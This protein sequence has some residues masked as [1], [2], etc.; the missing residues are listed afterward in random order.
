MT[1]P[2]PWNQVPQ[3]PRPW[4]DPL[5]LIVCELLA[6]SFAAVGPVARAA[7]LPASKPRMVLAIAIVASLAM[8]GTRASWWWVRLAIAVSAGA[9]LVVPQGLLIAAWLPAT[10]LLADW[11]VR[12]RRPF[13]L[14]PPAPEGVLVPVG[15]AVLVAAQLG[16]SEPATWEPLAAMAV[17]WILALLG[18]VMQKVIDRPGIWLRRRVGSAVAWIVTVPLDLTVLVLPWLARTA[19]RQPRADPR[20][21]GWTVR[22][23]RP[24]RPV[25]PWSTDPLPPLGALARLREVASVA[26]TMA[27]LVIVTGVGVSVFRVVAPT[28]TVGPTV[29]DNPPAFEGLEWYPDYLADVSWVFRESVAWRSLRDRRLLDVETGT[30]NIRRG[31]RTSWSPPACD[32]PR[33]TVWMYGGSTTFGLGQRDDH[34]IA[35]E[36][37]RAAWEEGIALDVVNRGMPGHGHWTEADRFSWDLT[38]EDPPDL[39]FFYDGVN[40]LWQSA[41]INERETNFDYVAIEPTTEEIA[42]GERPTG[43]P[44]K[45]AGA[46]LVTPPEV[47]PRT[48]EDLG[49][50]AAERYGRAIAMSEAT[51]RVH[52]IPV[53]WFWQPSRVTRPP[54][55]GEPQSGEY[56]QNLRDQARGAHGALPDDVIDL[57]DM[58]DANRDVMFWDDVHHNE[59]GARVIGARVFQ[60]LRPQ[61]EELL[62][63]T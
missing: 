63:G 31:V 4:T 24:T 38:V 57:T 62:A 10:L 54:I 49:R 40:E 50:L 61:L 58:L 34:T 11:V 6:L 9:V 2:R 18:T 20:P 52:N 1:A 29:A 53:M 7:A 5:S 44:P 17:A 60:E 13:P 22:H 21:A 37:A 39:V 15:I 3:R 36:I 26:L 46:K 30:I 41:Y 16:R 42:K 12:R 14:V 45:R 19:L 51:A 56:E 47:G 25:Q 43:D 28:A 48:N 33:L 8:A 59:V 27:I 55:E 23:R 32:C 35:S